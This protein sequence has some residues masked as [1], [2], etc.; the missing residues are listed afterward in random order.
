M[1]LAV[2][3]ELVGESHL[4][5]ALRRC[6]CGQRFLTIFAERVD[7][8]TGEDPQERLVV[9]ISAA[10][11]D[12]LVADGEALDLDAIA[13]LGADRDHLWV[14]WPSGGVPKPQWLRAPITI[15]P[16]D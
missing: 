7:W 6:V 8:A 16:H 5:V 3:V 10:E 4:V 12:A 15:P 14:D 11:G 13:A 1:N 9:P 2:A